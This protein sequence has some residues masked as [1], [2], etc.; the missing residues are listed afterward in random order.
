MVTLTKD[1]LLFAG[2]VLASYDNVSEDLR[3]PR[4]SSSDKTAHQEQK[5]AG[6]SKNGERGYQQYYY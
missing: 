2:P 6:L 1:R 5:E 3:A 4:A